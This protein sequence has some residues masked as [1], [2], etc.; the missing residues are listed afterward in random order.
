MRRSLWVWTGLFVLAL[1]GSA[2]AW[3][4]FS[5]GSGEPSTELTTPAVAGQTTTIGRSGEVTT[6]SSE[7]ESADIAFVIQ[8][9]E[10]EATFTLDE[11]LRGEPQTVVGATS[12]VAG[13]FILNLDD[14]SLTQFSDIVVNARTFATGSS[15]R[16]RAIRGPIILNSASDDFEFI[17]FVVREAVGLDGSADI[18]DTLTFTLLGDLTIRDQ[19]N[20]VEFDMTA[21]LVDETTVEGTATAEV[22]RSDFGIGIPNVPSVADVT[23]E[24]TLQLEFLATSS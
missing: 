1:G 4:W 13:Q 17:N 5:G 8:S 18:G 20:P 16:D 9:E 21:A 12:E 15:N 19:T 11:V 2:Y 14:L 22:L 10:S 23:D 7:G 24:V 6:S 3:F